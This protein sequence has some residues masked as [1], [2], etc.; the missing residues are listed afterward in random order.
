M[1]KKVRQW[2]TLILAVVMIVGAVNNDYLITLAT[3]ADGVGTEDVSGNAVETQDVSGNVVAE[4]G[5]V[6]GD[7][8]QIPAVYSAGINETP[9]GDGKDDKRIVLSTENIQ[10][11]YNNDGVTATAKENDMYELQLPGGYASS[12]FTLKEE[13]DL[14]NCTRVTFALSEQAGN[15]NFGLYDKTW[16]QSD[17]SHKIL[18]VYGKN[19]DA[20]EYCVEGF[21]ATENGTV[22]YTFTLTD[23]QKARSVAHIGV[24]SSSEASCVIHGVLLEMEGDGSDTPDPTPTPAGENKTKAVDAGN[25]GLVLPALKKNMNSY[26]KSTNVTYESDTVNGIHTITYPDGWNQIQFTLSNAV[27]LTQ[28]NKITFTVED[29]SKPMKFGLHYWSEETNTIDLWTATAEADANGYYTFDLNPETLTNGTTATTISVWSNGSAQTL[30]FHGVT[31]ENDPNKKFESTY[32]V[33]YPTWAAART[34]R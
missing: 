1:R 26:Y 8:A 16:Y 23:E 21:E 2:I 34:D 18:E 28:Y 29:A 17:G 19:A 22:Y 11:V 14:A 33:T 15:L 10:G 20:A 13:I 30:K 27:D 7:A 5:S 32:E 6:S 4:Q 9:A 24:S 31:F 3:N 12:V 25:T